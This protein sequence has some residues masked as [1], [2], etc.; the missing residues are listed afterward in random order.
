MFILSGL[1][2]MALAVVI[3]CY[4]FRIR[5]QFTVNV[6]R[7]RKTHTAGMNVTIRNK[8]NTHGLRAGLNEFFVVVSHGNVSFHNRLSPAVSSAF[9]HD[10][11]VQYFGK[12]RVWLKGDRVLKYEQL[13]MKHT[14]TVIDWKII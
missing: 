12:H 14:N 13:N 9:E 5:R 6:L 4:V 2:G 8:G 7:I 11:E 10:K 3:A 1:I